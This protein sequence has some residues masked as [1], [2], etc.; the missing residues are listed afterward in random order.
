MI[1]DREIIMAIIDNDCLTKSAAAILLEGDGFFRFQKAVDLYNKGTV[2]KIVFSG[3]IIDK[4]YGSFPFE[5]IKP[6]IVKGG[7]P[8]KDLIHEDESL[9]TRQQ[10]VE[11]VK[12]AIKKEWKKLA[13]V[14]SHEHQYR[15]YLTFLREVLDTKSG[16]ILY[17]APARNLNWFI[18]DGWG[19]RFERLSV[20]FER[21]EKYSA[22]GHLANMQ[23]VIEYQKWKES[24]LNESSSR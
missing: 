6:F 16:I 1:T 17:N 19:T 3:N 2:S 4:S 15:A 12:M 7:V 5:E 22:M 23:E 21:M 11:I 13:L 20:E 10:A 8:E 14:A 18:D 9:N 24:L